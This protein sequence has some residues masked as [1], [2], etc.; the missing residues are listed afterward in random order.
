[1]ALFHAFPHLND[2]EVELLIAKLHPAD[3]FAGYVPS[4]DFI[5]ALSA[6]H[7]PIGMLSVRIGHNQN[8]YYGGNV[9]YHIDPPYRGHHYAAK[10]CELAKQ[11][12]I[13]HR[14]DYFIITCNPDNHPSRR[15]IERAG[16]QFMEC[17]LLPEDN[18][19]YQAGEHYKL[20]YRVD[21]KHS[22]TQRSD[23]HESR[24]R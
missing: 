2:G 19:M 6:D 23:D 24:N 22:S 9:G 18:A 3:A 7:T 1:M 4:Y 15:T 5:I 11:V 16:G 14:M 12:G 10:A 17:V 8:T 20:I 21:F 13:R